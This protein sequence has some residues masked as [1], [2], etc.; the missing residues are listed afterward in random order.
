MTLSII[1]A[2]SE[3]NVIGVN[4]HLPW[5]L[6]VDM[7]YFKDMTMGK[8][9]VMGRKSFEELGRVL[10]GR[11]NIMITRQSDYK[12]EGL[13]I[14]PSLEAGIEKAKTF[15]TEEIFITGGGEI[16]KMALPIIDR[17]YLTRVHAEVSGD[18]Y[19]PEFDPR[20]WKLVKNERHEKDEKHAYALTFQVWEREK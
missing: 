19:F 6:P 12:A 11:P 15:G 1:V 2:A 8:P 4:N 14:V 20:G 5:H 13:Y 18:T 17:L 3:N 10:P 16:F 7:K 9:I